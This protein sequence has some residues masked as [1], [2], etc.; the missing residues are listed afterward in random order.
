[1]GVLLRGRGVMKAVD[2]ADILAS[3]A[4]LNAFDQELFDLGTR[5]LNREGG[6]QVGCMDVVVRRRLLEAF[7]KVNFQTDLPIVQAMRMHEKAARYEA[8]CEEVAAIWQKPGSI[9]GPG[10]QGC[11]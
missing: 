5:A 9:T 1:M 6:A 2:I 10:V 4:D 8:A 11:F 3:L 7:K